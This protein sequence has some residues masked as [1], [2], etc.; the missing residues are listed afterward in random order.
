M[1]SVFFLALRCMDFRW[2]K[3]QKEPQAID[4][5]SQTADFAY[6]TFAL[7][8]VSVFLFR[9]LPGMLGV[10]AVDF[11]FEPKRMTTLEEVSPIHN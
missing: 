4:F 11:F 3:S 1:R 2:A 6:I 9:Q 7:L 10:Q 5:C 8:D